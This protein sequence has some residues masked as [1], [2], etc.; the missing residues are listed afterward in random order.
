MALCWMGL[1]L[2]LELMVLGV[3]YDVW[4]VHFNDDLWRNILGY[5]SKH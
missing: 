4:Y 3:K 5:E 1:G 2:W